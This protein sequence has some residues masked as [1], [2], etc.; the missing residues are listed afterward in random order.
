MYHTT[1]CA[2]DTFYMYYVLIE[3]HLTLSAPAKT[4]I[5]EAYVYL[6]HNTFCDFARLYC[7]ILRL[8]MKTPALWK[9]WHI[10]PLTISDSIYIL[11]A[12][13]HK[14]FNHFRAND[15]PQSFLSQLDD[16]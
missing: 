4:F 6:G 14:A 10:L 15:L 3:G 1:T 2:W 13:V 5:G 8:L 7:K 16:Y 9:D 12:S 11:E